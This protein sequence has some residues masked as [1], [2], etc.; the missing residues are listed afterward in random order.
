MN[1]IVGIENTINWLLSNPT[2]YYW[3][4][5]D[6]DKGLAENRRALGHNFWMDEI[7]SPDDSV[8]VLR[9][10]LMHFTESG[11]RAYMWKVE[12]PKTKNGGYYTWIQIP[13]LHGNNMPQYING[14]PPQ[15]QQLT[16]EEI[17]Q[18]IQEGITRGLEE[19]QRKREMDELR[20]QVRQRD[21]LLKEMQPGVLDRFLERTEPYWEP[22]ISGL[23]GKSLLKVAAPVAA[24]GRKP[25][26]QNRQAATPRPTGTETDE[27]GI[28]IN[29]ENETADGLTLMLDNAFTTLTDGDPDFPNRLI[30]L[31]EMKKNNPKLYNMALSMLEGQ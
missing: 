3:K 8:R 30:K 21:A 31:A 24:I 22:M 20:E 17:K 11:L 26:A 7:K 14:M 28:L 2:C 4:L 23:L 5:F 1:T 29:T 27:N 18:Q 16:Q 15:N 10:L 9:E 25:A 19:Y 12:S 6:T 13:A